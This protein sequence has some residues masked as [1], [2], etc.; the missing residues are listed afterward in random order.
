MLVGFS[1]PLVGLF[2]LLCSAC[3]SQCLVEVC[4]GWFYSVCVGWFLFSVCW[5]VSVNIC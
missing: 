2:Q 3:F 4:V 1:R 5:L